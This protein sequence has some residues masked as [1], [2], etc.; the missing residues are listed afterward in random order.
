MRAST[1]Y[2]QNL[3]IAANLF[4][5]GNINEWEPQCG[6]ILRRHGHCYRQLLEKNAGD[7]MKGSRFERGEIRSKLSQLER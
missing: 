2:N 7:L 1:V 5:N 4:G 6:V 3:P